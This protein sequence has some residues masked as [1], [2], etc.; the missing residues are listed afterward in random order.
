M[1]HPHPPDDSKAG[2]RLTTVIIVV[3]LTVFFLAGIYV[4]SKFHPFN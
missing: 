2:L 4:G 3:V 1:I